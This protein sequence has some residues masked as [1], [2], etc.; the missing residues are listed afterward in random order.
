MWYCPKEGCVAHQM[1]KGR[2]KTPIDVA[3]TYK[4]MNPVECRYCGTPVVPVTEETP[5]VQTATDLMVSTEAQ[6]A[7][8]NSS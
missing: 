8:D 3:I 7:R 2:A 6:Y 4:V 1:E 5:M